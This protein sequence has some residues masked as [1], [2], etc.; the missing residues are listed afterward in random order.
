[1]RPVHFDAGHDIFRKQVLEIPLRVPNNRRIRNDSLD[2]VVSLGRMV[3][4]NIQ[5]HL[6]PFLKD[7]LDF[8]RMDFAR[9]RANWCEVH[10]VAQAFDDGR[11]PCSTAPD[12][13]VQVRIQGHSCPVKESALPFDGEQ[14]CVLR[15]FQ[16]AFL[17]MQP[18]S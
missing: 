10:Y 1:M 5:G 4:A 14:F 17:G 15:Q 9:R 3:R 6:G 16:L 8:A 2:P 13:H 11:L 18:Y 12:H 7:T